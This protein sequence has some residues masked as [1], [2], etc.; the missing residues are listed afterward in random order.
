[1]SQGK[2]IG[3]V[4]SPGQA[5]KRNDSE[6]KPTAL[7]GQRPGASP[8][9]ALSSPDDRGPSSGEPM[10]SPFAPRNSRESWHAG[11]TDSIKA[12]KA[13]HWSIANCSELLPASIATFDLLDQVSGIVERRCVNDEGGKLLWLKKTLIS[14]VSTLDNHVLKLTKDEKNG[15]DSLP[16]T[17]DVKEKLM[18]YLQQFDSIYNFLSGD[19]PTINMVHTVQNLNNAFNAYTKHL[20][21]SVSNAVAWMRY[22]EIEIPPEG[23]RSTKR[24]DRGT[25]AYGM[26]HNDCLE[27]T[28]EK[29]LEAIHSWIDDND[30]DNEHRMFLLMDVAGS[31]KSTVSKHMALELEEARVLMARF[32]FS[33]DNDATM[34]TES[35]C[36][37]VADFFAHQDDVFKG[38]MDTFKQRPDYRHLSFEEQFKGLLVVP[39]NALDRPTVLII[40]ALDECDKR[41]RGK[42]LRSLAKYLPSIRHLRVFITG[43]PE[44]DIKEWATK[45][46]A[47]RCTNFRELE[48]GSDDVK[49]YIE[50]R[51]SDWSTSRQDAIYNVVN[52]AEGLFIWARIA[53]DLL[54]QTTDVER[55]LESLRKEVTLENLYTVA[56]EESVPRDKYSRQATI[57]V[58]QMILATRQ[59]LSIRELKKLCSK[60]LF[61]NSDIVEAV[62]LSLGS[63]LIYQAQGDPIRLLHT[64]LGEFLTNR[65]KARAWFVQV[66]IGHYALASGC[67]SFISSMVGQRNSYAVDETTQRLLKY[68]SLHWMYHCEASDRKLGL[69]EE[70][71]DFLDEGYSHSLNVMAEDSTVRVHEHVNRLCRQ[72]L[73]PLITAT[74]ISRALKWAERYEAT[75]D[76]LHNQGLNK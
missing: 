72:N 1:M 9:P 54:V 7:G 10:A 70:V 11:D 45:T 38:V 71:I 43:R 40:D 32:F 49:T 15:N 19:Q 39:F 75:P 44:R 33:R 48:D 13:P 2:Q 46:M 76:V 65:S 36:S 55:L 50:H 24:T 29:T 8:G 62:V 57:A 22:S 16:L 12:L 59:S 27:G 51:L 63:I 34:N 23:W 31:G 25:S 73:S 74:L 5:H 17:Q 37:T 28:R 4:R 26:Q 64:T 53:C 66:G 20:H 58:L 35:F 69:N 56:L 67:I 52:H 6:R 68:S 61:R 3:K 18:L 30:G 60:K 42:L 21:E 14:H 41:D 47:V